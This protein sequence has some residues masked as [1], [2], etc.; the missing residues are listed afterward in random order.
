MYSTCYRTHKTCLCTFP[1]HLPLIIPSLQHHVCLFHH[2][3]Y[4]T[5]QH[6]LTPPQNLTNYTILPITSYILHPYVLHPTHYTATYYTPM[7]YTTTYYTPMYYTTTYYTL[8]I[9]QPQNIPPHIVYITA[10]TCTVLFP[11]YTIYL[12]SNDNIQIYVGMYKMAVLVAPDSSFDS[13]EPLT[14]EY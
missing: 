7:Y 4:W 3:I 9:T 10:Y 6:I 8:R 11:T 12:F 1:L 2:P 13:Y 14:T 5:L